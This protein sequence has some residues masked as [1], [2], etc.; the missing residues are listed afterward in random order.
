MA[1]LGTAPPG[2][3]LHGARVT[4]QSFPPSAEL[5]VSRSGSAGSFL[6]SWQS[7]CDGSFRSTCQGRAG[8][9]ESGNGLFLFSVNHKHALFSLGIQ[10]SLTVWEYL[11][12]TLYVL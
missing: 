7:A 6:S 8:R 3:A 11:L 9:V 2:T 1:G 5:G 4:L 10:G 12:G